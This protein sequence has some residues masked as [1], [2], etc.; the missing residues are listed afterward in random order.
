M[1]SSPCLPLLSV[2][3]HVE[4]ASSI[5]CLLIA[6]KLWK[7]VASSVCSSCV[8]LWTR[9]MYLDLEGPG[10]TCVCCPLTA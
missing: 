5:F 1:G 4:P 9:V 7:P 2:P 10:V 8:I 3:E 6:P